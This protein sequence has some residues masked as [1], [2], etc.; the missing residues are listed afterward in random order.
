MPVTDVPAWCRW[1]EGR[2]PLLLVAPHGGHA[3]TTTAR[4]ASTKVNDVHTAEL[5]WELATCL[6]AA[7]IVNPVLDRNQLDLNRISQV[8]RDAA[9][10]PAL[11]EHLLAQLLA[12]HDVVEVLFIHGWNV[13]QPKCDIGVGAHF[14]HE[15]DA[16]PLA[17]LTAAAGYIGERLHA[18]RTRWAAAGVHTTYGERYPGSHR[19]NMLQLFRRDGSCP[20]AGA[21]RL[22]EW[23]AA[24]RL[25]AVQL[26]LGVPLRWPGRRRDAF[27]QALLDTFRV[28]GTPEVVSGPETSRV[29]DT[30]AR[31]PP[32][33]AML[34]AYDAAARL[35]IMSSVSVQPNGQ[36]GGR[37]LLFSHGQTM[38]LFT[39]EDPLDRGHV[40]GGPAFALRDGGTTLA[41]RGAVLQV[42]DAASYIRLEQAFLQSRLVEA[43]IMLSFTP[44][45]GASYGRVHGR[46]RLDGVSNDIDTLGFRDVPIFLRRAGQAASRC[47]V[48]VAASSDVGLHAVTT[49]AGVM[50][51]AI[52][53]CS[54]TETVQTQTSI[55]EDRAPTSHVPARLVLRGA[56]TLVMDPVSYMQIRRPLPDGGAE[57]IFLGLARCALET[58]AAAY[59]FYEY[60]RPF[61]ADLDGFTSAESAAQ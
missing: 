61:A 24:G 1:R 47:A 58:G 56:R 5:T 32:Q 22:A 39:G 29:A 4:T 49:E 38:A 6:D 19:N 36:L 17:H 59:G 35:G 12:A 40:V 2:R 8:T 11:I 53:G 44:T 18:L 26:E 46:V 57:M 34:L 3:D 37:L 16:V 55:H 23:A 10:F 52:H 14:E 41:F 31:V 33:A 28:G 15:A 51:W 54:G 13:I 21:P 27:V 9:W 25:N 60:V 42:R 50:D 48:A 30:S 43:E 7:A 45:Y 20:H